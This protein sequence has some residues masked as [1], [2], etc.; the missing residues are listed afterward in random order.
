MTALVPPNGT[1]AGGWRAIPDDVV[2]R[3]RGVSW[4]DDDPRCPPLEV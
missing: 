2:A 1:F 4:R 3:M